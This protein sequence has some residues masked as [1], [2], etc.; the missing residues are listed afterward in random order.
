[1]R[2]VVCHNFYKQ[3][4]G[5]DRVFRDETTLLESSGHR[6]IRFTV[7]N[8][9]TDGMSP[10]SLAASAVWNRES[11]TLLRDLVRKT[12]ADVVHFHNTVPLVSP[13]AY[14]AARKAGAAVVQSLHNY[15]TIC[16]KATFFRDGGVCESCLGRKVALPAVVHACY[17]ESRAASATLAGMLAIHGL[18][19]TYRRAVDAYI[20]MSQFARRKLIEGGLPAER[21]ALK[22]NFVSPDPGAGAGR[23]GYAMF[24]GRLS[25]EKGVDVLLEAWRQMAGG[26]PLRIVGNGPLAEDVRSAARA[27]ANV[28]WL[29]GKDDDEVRRLMQDAALLVLPSVNYEGFPKTIVE[30][31][32][33]GTPVVASR[34]G[35]M[36]EIVEDG[37]TGAHFTAGDAADLAGKIELLMSTPAT[38]AAMRRAC[39][40]EYLRKY[41]AEQN[42]RT[43]IEV[44]ER[45][46]SVR[47]GEA[48]RPV[49]AALT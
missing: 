15:R 48:P 42:Y 9:T 41:T 49:D 1:M 5:E 14:Y 32:S 26:V 39:R 27:N 7:H 34:L 3:P 10:L 23:S 36:Q 35:A 31:F 2:V 38:L 18:L 30:A 24:L 17:R 45:A 28:E 25:P 4:G 37:R 12:Q 20:A 47:R 46:V 33:V 8:D 43:L 6:V 11:A 29:P 13:S 44:Y 40:D 21:I 16:P 22:P 19:G